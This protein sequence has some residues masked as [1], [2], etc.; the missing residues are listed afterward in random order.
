MI[1][2][3]FF[4]RGAWTTVC[5]DYMLPCVDDDGVWVPVFCNPEGDV[6]DEKE[7]WCCCE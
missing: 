5:I 1:G 7:L 3:K 6:P 4:V 2:I